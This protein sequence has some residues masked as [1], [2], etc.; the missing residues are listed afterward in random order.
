MTRVAERPLLFSAP[1]VLALLARA[2]TQTRRILKLPPRLRHWAP[3]ERHGYPSPDTTVDE[4]GLHIEP[5]G[6]AL[7]DPDNEDTY[8][9]LPCPYGSPGDRLWVKETWRTEEFESDAEDLPAGTAGVRFAA[10]GA[11]L[12]IEN[13]SE[14]CEAWAIAHR[15]P[16]ASNGRWRP[17]IFMSRWASRL[18]LEVLSVRV[19]RLQSISEADAL[20]EGIDFCSAAKHLGSVERYRLLW[21]SINGAGSW[22]VNP[23]VWVVEFK[24]P[25]ADAVNEAS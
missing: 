19:E 14:A 22:V 17:S 10:D 13:T 7:D 20:A 25:A 16:S 1:M 23:W 8:D 6:K 15:K 9:V 4:R 11:F 18:T 24:Q 21:E 5:L 12:L 3:C 2:K